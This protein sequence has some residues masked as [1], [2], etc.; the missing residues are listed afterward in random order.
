MIPGIE[1]FRACYNKMFG[2]PS[3]TPQTN[4]DNCECCLSC[5]FACLRVYSV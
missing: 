3:Y 2:A 4:Y 5:V 1:L